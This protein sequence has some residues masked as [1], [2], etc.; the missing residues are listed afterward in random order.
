MAPGARPGSLPRASGPACPAPAALLPLAPV[1][2]FGRT[3]VSP[4]NLTLLEVA[5]SARPLGATAA[6]VIDKIIVKR[7]PGW[8]ATE[9]TNVRNAL[10]FVRHVLTYR[11]PAED[12]LPE[13]AAW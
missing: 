2:P 6:Q 11:E 9:D 13:V 7:L 3:A 4:H 10:A 1:D 8:G 5:A 12:D